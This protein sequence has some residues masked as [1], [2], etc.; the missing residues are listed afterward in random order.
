MS[1]GKRVIGGDYVKGR[2][3]SKDIEE[4]RI[5]YLEK[6]WS[7]GRWIEELRKRVISERSILA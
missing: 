3:R 7:C 1:K 5:E 4:G 2:I 6:R